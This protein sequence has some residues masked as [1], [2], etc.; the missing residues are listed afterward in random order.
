MPWW[1][2]DLKVLRQKA[3]RA[4]HKAYINLALSKTGK[5]TVRCV[6]LLRSCYGTAKGT[7]GV[8]FVQVWR[9][10]INHQE[11]T[12]FLDDLKLAT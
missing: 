4:F 12:K 9:T 1:N 6:D 3:N 11:F 5:H 8:T 10:H 7:L 2:H